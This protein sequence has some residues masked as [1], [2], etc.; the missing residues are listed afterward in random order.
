MDIDVDDEAERQG[1]VANAVQSILMMS[2]DG[3]EC[4]VTKTGDKRT[5][6]RLGVLRA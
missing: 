3:V 5:V 1:Q 4:L 6:R 2:E